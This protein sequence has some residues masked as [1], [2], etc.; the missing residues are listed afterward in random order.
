MELCL[1][2]LTEVLSIL[3]PMQLTQGMLLVVSTLSI[4]VKMLA[5]VP[6]SLPT[7]TGTDTSL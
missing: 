4:F 2:R 6:H 1:P 5:A 3:M 7:C